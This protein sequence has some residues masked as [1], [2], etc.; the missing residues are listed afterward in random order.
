MRVLLFRTFPIVPSCISSPERGP[1]ILRFN[2]SG[3]PLVPLGY[4]LVSCISFLINTTQDFRLFLWA[5][6]LVYLSLGLLQSH[7]DSV[8]I[9]PP[10]PSSGCWTP[11]ALSRSTTSATHRT[12]S[13]S[14]GP[15]RTFSDSRARCPRSQRGPDRRSNL[16][17]RAH[18]P[19]NQN[20]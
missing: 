3:F 19:L 12:Q 10:S 8:P 13:D 18:Q 6:A 11:L 2:L 14:F 1:E 9:F 5:T 16:F 17:V 7:P 4:R 15:L 20:S